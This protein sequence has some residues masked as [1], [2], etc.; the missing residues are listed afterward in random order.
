MR[1]GATSYVI[2][3]DL[4]ANAARLA[5]EVE[6]MELVLYDVEGYGT[7]LPDGDTIAR[8]ND[9]AAAHG[10]TYTV[11]LPMDLCASGDRSL[12]LARRTIEATQGLAPWAYVAHLNGSAL[13]DG[14]TA[15]AA[16]RW[17]EDAL[18]ALQAVC[19]LLETPQCLSVENIERWDPTFLAPLLEALP[20]SRCVDV[21]H[22]WLAGQDPLTHLSAWLPR[23]R[24]VHLHGL[25]ERDHQ[26]LSLAPAEQLDALV[27][28]LDGAPDAV[29]TLEVFGEVDYVT[30][31]EAWEQ[32]LRRVRGA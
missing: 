7:N 26:S 2:E 12:E 16:A 11:H 30:S 1:I 10:L 3:G 28:L 5:G 21:G 14:P 24:V 19:A 6:D 25:G 17:Q 23:T 32:A 9:L 27:A 13:L 18:Q 29:V 15:E 8:L 22:L 20:I 4:A 31:R